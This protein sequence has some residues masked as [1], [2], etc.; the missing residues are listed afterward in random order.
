M[1]QAFVSAYCGVSKDCLKALH[2]SSSSNAFYYITFMLVFGPIIL[3]IALATT[4]HTLLGVEWNFAIATAIAVGIVVAFTDRYFVIQRIKSQSNRILRFEF[5]FLR[6][7]TWTVM[8]FLG[9]STTANLLGSSINAH[10]ADK[11][12]QEAQLILAKDDQLNSLKKQVE[13]ERERQTKYSKLIEKKQEYQLNVNDYERKKIA[14]EQG[15]DENGKLIAKG[16]GDKYKKNEENSKKASNNV[17]A[18]QSQ[19]E[20]LAYSPQTTT[21]LMEQISKRET[22][23]KKEVKAREDGTL[24][25]IKALYEI[26]KADKIKLLYVV[27]TVI[28]ALIIE[29]AYTLALSSLPRNNTLRSLFDMQQKNEIAKLHLIRSKL[30]ADIQNQQP[31]Q[32][33][34][35][36][37]RPKRLWEQEGNADNMD[38]NSLSA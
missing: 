13:T 8:I 24:N 38:N 14:E 15:I 3:S 1:F 36:P 20:A 5:W 9:I 21:R 2:N 7:L 4:L 27:F 22:E 30:R 12:H 35:L 31:V 33:V 23:L 6:L 25:R 26:I 18:I 11:V 32:V 37:N 34:E 16:R 19:I 29:I 10:T 17:K 28:I